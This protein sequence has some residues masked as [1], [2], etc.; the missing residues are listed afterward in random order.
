MREMVLLAFTCIASL[1]KSRVALSAENL[2]FRHQ[3]CVLQLS[4][5]RAEARPADRLLWSMLARFWANWKGAPMFVKPD[6]V[7]RRQPKRIKEH[8]TCLSKQGKAGRPTIPEELIRTM[9]RKNPT[10]GFPKIVGELAKLG[11]TVSKSTIET[12]RVSASKAPS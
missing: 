12:Y 6:T 3:L 5:K 8:W 10:W 1:F 11:I 7:I 2:A 4:V 9:S